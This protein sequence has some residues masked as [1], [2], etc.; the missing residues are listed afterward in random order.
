MNP[1]TLGKRATIPPIRSCDSAG[2]KDAYGRRQVARQ[3]HRAIRQTRPQRPTR[4]TSRRFAGADARGTGTGQLISVGSFTT[5]E[6]PIP[7][8]A[9]FVQ[10]TVNKNTGEVNIDKYYA[11]HDCGTPI[12]PEL[13]KGQ[14]YGGVLKTIGHSLYEELKLLHPNSVNPILGGISFPLDPLYF[15]CFHCFIYLTTLLF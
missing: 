7:Y 10:V 5:D 6:A 13:A 9:H 14:I 2:A 1:P 4:A 8:G 15:S 3:K 12:N 11:L